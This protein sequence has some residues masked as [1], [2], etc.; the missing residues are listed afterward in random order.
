MYINRFKSEISLSRQVQPQ[1][2]LKVLGGHS[3]KCKNIKEDRA[4]SAV[5]AGA[6]LSALLQAVHT[7]AEREVLFFLCFL[8]ISQFAL[9]SGRDETTQRRLEPRLPES[10]ALLTLPASSSGPAAAETERAVWPPL[11]VG[12]PSPVRVPS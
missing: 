11:E 12:S 10:L 9:R 4:S 7:I 1:V 2:F 8:F 3:L 6:G 5:T